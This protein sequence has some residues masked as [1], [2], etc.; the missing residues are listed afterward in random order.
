[1]ASVSNLTL[2]T[3]VWDANDQRIPFPA[4][5]KIKLAP[6]YPQDPG[7]GQNLEA[8]VKTLAW[9]HLEQR[10][11]GWEK[12]DGAFGIFVFDASGRLITL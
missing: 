4:V 8:A 12:N 10:H 6:E 3:R 2:G 9:H 1:M 5:T 11:E 7:A